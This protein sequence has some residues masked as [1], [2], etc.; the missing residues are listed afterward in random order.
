MWTGTWTATLNADGTYTMTGVWESSAPPPTPPPPT[1]P[2][3]VNGSATPAPVAAG[4]NITITIT[5][6]LGNDYVRIVDPNGSEI[7]RTATTVAGNNQFIMPLTEENI[8]QQQSPVPP[9]VYTIEY[10]RGGSNV[11]TPISQIKLTVTG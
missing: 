4:G 6:D 7:Q 8:F 2:F 3:L 9:G 10:D 11:P 5:G 1:A